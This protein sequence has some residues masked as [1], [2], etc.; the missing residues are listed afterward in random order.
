LKVLRP[1]GSP[2]GF[3]LLRSRPI[4]ADEIG[5]LYRRVRLRSVMLLAVK[6]GNHGL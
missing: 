1:A 5:S 4:L 6:A 3:A 2:C